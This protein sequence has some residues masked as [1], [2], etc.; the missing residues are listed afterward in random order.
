M[1]HIT[2]QFLKM[3]TNTH[4]FKN[5]QNNFYLKRVIYF[6]LGIA[7]KGCEDITEFILALMQ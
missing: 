4:Y 6:G 2:G 3:N 1:R 7:K 5:K